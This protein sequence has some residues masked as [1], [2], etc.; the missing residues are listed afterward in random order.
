M[1][2]T[3]GWQVYTQFKSTA[4]ISSFLGDWT[5]PTDPTTWPYNNKTR[6]QHVIYLFT[7]LQSDDWVP[8]D[9]APGMKFD[10]IQPVLQWGYS[11]PNGGGRFW[12]IASWYLTLYGH[13][14]WS[15]LVPVGP[16]EVIFGNMT[17]VKDETWYI[18][19]NV[20]GRAKDTLTA[21][22]HSSF[23]LRQQPWAF[24]TLETY[25]EDSCEQFPPTKAQ[26]VF[27]NL[28]LKDDKGNTVTP[29]WSRCR[30]Q[31]QPRVCSTRITV[32]NTE[33]ITIGF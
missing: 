30:G 25:S 33:T 32:N 9:P 24:V 27:T 13:T 18:S 5:V 28:V 10:I 15:K 6:H 14:L 16:N 12:G 2:N 11:D 19:T 26:S 22:T 4:G 20:K 31:N 8:G 7:G 29:K 17:R 3:D 21:L 1:K 23:R